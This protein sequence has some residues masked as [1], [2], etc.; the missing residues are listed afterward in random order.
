MLW[1]YFLRNVFRA[2]TRGTSAVGKLSILFLTGI[3]SQAFKVGFQALSIGFIVKTKWHT[4]EI[5]ACYCLTT[6]SVPSLNKINV[7]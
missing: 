5:F 2:T 1:N 3:S 7:K 4:M 6:I